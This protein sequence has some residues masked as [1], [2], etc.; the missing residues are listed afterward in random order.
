MLNLSTLKFDVDTSALVEAKKALDNLAVAQKN[1][2]ATGGNVGKGAGA[3]E[4]GV[5]NLG[6]G[7]ERTTNSLKGMER[8][9]ERQATKMQILRGEVVN[10]GNETSKL[11]RAFTAGQAG[12]LASAKI[13]GATKEQFEK[14]ASSFTDLNKLM[15]VNPF[16]KSASGVNAL[17]KEVDELRNVNKL[18]SEG[19]K[20]TTQEIR[21]LSRDLDAAKQSFDNGQLSA[22]KYEQVVAGI[23]A[24]TIRLSA[25]KANLQQASKLLEQQVKEEATAHQRAQKAQQIVATEMQRVDSILNELNREHS[26]GTILSER[27]ANSISRFATQL[28]A[29]GITGATATAQLEQYRGKMQQ[30]EAIENKRA[31]NR[32]ANALAPQISDVAVSLAGG[33]PLHLV[34]MQQGLQIRDLIGQSGVAA[35][36]LQQTMRDA[37]KNMVVSIAGTVAALG[38]MTYGALADAGKAF[39]GFAGK[40]TGTSAVLSSF[41]KQLAVSAMLGDKFSLAMLSATRAVQVFTVAAA[42]TGIGALVI[43]LTAAA[44][45]FVQLIGA[46]NDLARELAV[47]GNMFGV[48]TDSSLQYVEGLTRVGAT[49]REAIS[50]LGAMS[51]AGNLSREQIGLIGK[52]AVDME[53]AAGV[54]IGDTVKR[55]SDLAKDPVKALSTLQVQTGAVQPEIIKLVDE[56]T[57]QG[58]AARASGVAV[59]ELARIMGVQSAKMQEDLHPL[60]QAWVGFK[61][62][63]SEVWTGIGNG[64]NRAMGNVPKQQKLLEDLGKLQ[65]LQVSG[66]NSGESAAL[67]RSLNLGGKTVKDRISEIGREL[68]LIDKVAQA[69]SDRARQRAEDEKAR[70]KANEVEIKYLEKAEQ[71]KRAIAQ[72]DKDRDLLAAQ[73]KPMS[74]QAYKE[75]KQKI[76]D[77]FKPKAN[78]AAAKEVNYYAASIEKL[79][80]AYVKVEVSANNYNDIQKGLLDIFNDPK[81]LTMGDDG[82]VALIRYAESLLAASKAVDDLA[83]AEKQREKD[84]EQYNKILSESNKA[85]EDSLK[86][87]KDSAKSVEERLAAMQEENKATALSQQMNISLAEA[88]ELTS[89]AR[90][91]EQQIAAMGDESKV[92]AIQREIDAREKLIEEMRIRESKKANDEHRKR[93]IEEWD[94]TWEQIS[95]SFIDSLMQGGKSVSE[96]L[97][98][99]FRTLVLQP[100]LQPV[101]KGVS[102]LAETAG[103]FLLGGKP[104]EGGGKSSGF[105]TSMINTGLST[106]LGGATSV[107]ALGSAFGAGFMSTI[108]AGGSIAGGSAA[109]LLAGGG[110]AGTSMLG[111]LGAIAPWVLGVVS[112]AASWKSLFGRKLKDAGI[113]GTFGGESGFTGNAYQFYKGGLFRSNKTTTGAMD[114]GMQQGLAGQFKAL[115][116]ASAGMAATLGLGTEAIQNFTASI[117]VS[118]NGLKEEEIQKKLQEEFDKLADSMASAV[119][120]TEQYNRAG[121]TSSQ[122]LTRLASS[123]D[124]VNK[125]FDMLGH[126]MYTASLAGADMSS[127]LVD[128]FGGVEQFSA[129][130]SAYYEAFYS[131]QE[132]L[133]N[134]TKQLTTAFANLGLELP[135]TIAGYRALVQNQ[136]M[137]TDSG[138]RLYTALIQLSPLFAEVANAVTNVSQT[139]SK[140]LLQMASDKSIANGLKTY[141]QWKEGLT[142][143][144]GILE[145]AVAKEI[146][147]LEDTTDAAIKALEGNADA[148]RS[149]LAEI[150]AGT[151]ALI[152]NLQRVFDL[153]KQNTDEL[154]ANTEA[155]AQFQALQGRQ[156]IQQALM[157]ARSGG[158]LPGADDLQRA[159]GFS[160]QGLDSGLYASKVD[161]DRQTLLLANELSELQKY[162]G[163]QLTDAQKQLQV[164]QEQLKLVDSLLEIQRN[165]LQNDLD[166]RRKELTDMLNL[167]REQ[168]DAALGNVK[169]TMSLTD[170]MLNLAGILTNKQPLEDAIAPIVAAMK[171]G[172][173]TSDAAANSLTA[174]GINL[175]P[176]GSTNVQGNSIYQSTGGAAAIMNASDATQSIINDLT[177]QSYLI[178][179][180]IAYVNDRLAANDPLS[181]YREAVNRGI[182]SGDLDNIMG[183]PS[184]TSRNWAIGNGLPSFAVGTNYVKHDMLAQIHEGEA[185]IPAKHNPYNPQ[186]ETQTAALVSALIEEVQML[187]AETRAVVNN[188]AKTSRILDDVTQDGD[189]LKV[190]IV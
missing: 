162:A 35:E 44:V 168:V 160:R 135:N 8:V 139:I 142:S 91:R 141:E 176:G 140:E 27:H 4:K 152:D 170:A 120:G 59:E 123:L 45:A 53:R 65:R 173:I 132:K 156:F 122:T 41:E 133:D 37:M 52:A 185:I 144:L 36:Q 51:K 174:L 183:W 184:G 14:L 6:K 30:I 103:N 186:N 20:L 165:Q 7:A 18:A 61:N 157:Q 110:A 90:L 16:D 42:A 189:T 22:A 58:N 84:Q 102:S 69:E 40:V 175:T 50:I 43:G 92:L 111:T 78:S 97:K 190:E 64:I 188:T 57:K 166:T 171:A 48:T 113:E 5:D 60:T 163:D 137:T 56:L 112:L 15:G 106:V 62:L 125:T 95:Q 25:E 158:T 124:T 138:R 131:E 19:I 121:E 3:A 146:K 148:E 143:A 161:R 10:L 127:Q 96:Y 79:N 77:D 88:I 167:Q 104:Q 107:G 87:Y 47:T 105:L 180:V 179:D 72:L 39:I 9:L 38:Q 75:A 118:F 100:I 129:A 86:A 108:S 66:I 33:M 11:D 67:L 82:K 99:L 94:K 155:T 151:N 81:F 29:A 169:A 126:T 32:L 46:N 76:E 147:S 101:Q 114:A 119:L 31:Q 181:V 117:K 70:V 13:A 178:R 130:T 71:K 159:I 93:E 182:S 83:A 73:G 85:Y 150:E 187:R 136:D 55:F 17:A 54:A 154:Y 145:D 12:M 115:Q 116:F 26:E 24:E 149:R 128:L 98:G 68:L 80:D 28:K 89:I 177:G 74:S 172:T 21:N 1:L 109:G 134:K 34:I 63:I 2:G 49:T 23:R 153:L 164:L